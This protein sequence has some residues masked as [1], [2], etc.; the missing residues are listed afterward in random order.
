VSGA[1][2]RALAIGARRLGASA[3]QAALQGP[4]ADAARSLL[5][6]S[7]ERPDDPRPRG[8]RHVDPSWIDHALAGEDAAVRAIVVGDRDDP[9]AR[10]LARWFLG[11]LVPMPS[12]GPATC[13]DELPRLP[14]RALARTLDAIGRRQLAHAIAPATPAEHATLAARLPWGRALSGEIAAVRS[15][16]DAAV[17]QLGRR[18]SALQRTADLAWPD[19]IAPLLAGARAIAPS[20]HGDLAAQIAQRLPHPIGVRVLAE[21]TGAW[22]ADAVA[23]AEVRRAIAQAGP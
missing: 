10:W 23:P 15:L 19:A 2:A 11:A 21:L 16:G 20:V 5:G 9:T 6:A 4:D 8:W 18:T 17:A 13:V 22:P 14:A 1:V 3:G 12:P 7:I